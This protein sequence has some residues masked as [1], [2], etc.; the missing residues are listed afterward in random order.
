MKKKLSK[1][2][3]KI[4]KEHYNGTVDCRCPIHDACTASSGSGW[5]HYER[6]VDKVNKA[7]SKHMKKVKG[8]VQ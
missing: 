4:C 7:A 1:T 2:V 5:D 8:E 6:W 3:L